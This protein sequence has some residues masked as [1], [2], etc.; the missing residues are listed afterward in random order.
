MSESTRERLFAARVYVLVGAVLAA[1]GS[2]VA[3]LPWDLPSSSPSKFWNALA[4]FALLGIVSDSLFFKIPI[5]KAN[6]SLAFIPLLATVALFNHPWPMLISGST[7]LVVDTFVR[8]KP[9]IRIVFNTAQY[10]LAVG[11]GGR[12]Y[13][14]LGGA[15]G[16]R[17]VPFTLIPFHP[18]RT[19]LFC[20][21]HGNRV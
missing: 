12:V 16:L 20:I 19:P 2:L 14:F 10:M 4:A 18:P 13:R 17:Q 3:M 8:R 15:G 1:S 9:A 6:A 21:K 7:A 5:A 11:V